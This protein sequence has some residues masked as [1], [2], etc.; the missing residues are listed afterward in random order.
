MNNK[1]EEEGE[2]KIGNVQI[3]QNKH[4]NLRNHIGGEKLRRIVDS[5]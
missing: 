3:T 2:V 5:L 1:E 4:Q